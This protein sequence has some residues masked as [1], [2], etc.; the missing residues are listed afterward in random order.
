MSKLKDYKQALDNYYFLKAK[1]EKPKKKDGK[2]VNDSIKYC[3]KCKKKGGTE[4]LRK[5]EKNERGERKSV[6]L[7]CRCKA[8]NPCDLNIEISLASYK[9]Y[10]DLVKSIK[11]NMEEVKTNIIKLKLD[12]LFQL[13][14]EE[15]VVNKFEQLKN[16][17]QSLSK[18]LNKLQTTYEEKNNTF[19]IKR[20]NEETNDEYEE[21]INRKK[22][23]I[24]TSKEIEG[25]I[26][27]YGKLIEDYKKTKNKSYLLD[28]FEKYHNQIVDLFNKKRKIQYQEGN[29]EFVKEGGNVSVEFDFKKVSIENKQVSLNRFEI[30]KNIY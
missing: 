28:A 12:L 16:K 13:K 21:K 15:Y 6:T 25:L 4:F 18:K 7:I 8:D 22:G 26:S 17:L 1:Y 19:I 9:L 24:I 30:V 27:K 11:E 3:I 29:V 2:V 5:V 14:D 23:I 20:K 10:E